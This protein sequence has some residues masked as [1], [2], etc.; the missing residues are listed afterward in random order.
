MTQPPQST[1]PAPPSGPPPSGPP[2][3]WIQLTLQGNALTSSVVPPTVRL[4][5]Y[6]VATAY[7]VNALPVPAGRW[8]IEVHCQWLRQ[9]GQAS[10]DVDVAP[11]QQV[12]VFYVAPMHQFTTGSIGFEEQKRK[13]MALFVG[14]MAFIGVV[15][16]LL[17]VGALL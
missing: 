10:L 6:P 2:A 8:R 17:V 12:P 11:G 13:G 16:A 15:V 7:G 5:G 9:F 3:G 4:N 1:P 14:L